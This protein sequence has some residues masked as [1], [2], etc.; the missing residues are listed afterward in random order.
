MWPSQV[1]S[2]SL[3]KLGEQYMDC[4]LALSLT[5]YFPA[6]ALILPFWQGTTLPTSHLLGSCSINYPPS[7]ISQALPVHCFFFLRLCTDWRLDTEQQVS[8]PL[9]TPWSCL[10]LATNLLP[11]SAKLLDSMACTTSAHLIHS[12]PLQYSL[13]KRTSFPYWQNQWN[14]HM[15]SHSTGRTHGMGGIVPV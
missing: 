5:Y 6:L 10:P 14:K 1:L 12:P 9:P 2:T 3:G 15:Q 11:F 8:F 4:R 13:V 7:S